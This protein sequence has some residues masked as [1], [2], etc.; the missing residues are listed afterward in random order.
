[1]QDA[2]QRVNEI[3]RGWVNY[4]RVGNASRA[5]AKV[6]YDVELKVRRFAM[7]QR[8]RSGFGWKR[9]SH[10]RRDRPSA[11][12]RVWAAVHERRCRRRGW[13]SVGPGDRTRLRR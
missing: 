9:W 12:P 8:K 11:T 6:R 7:R 2:V 10:A 1:M 13:A 5:F 4:F 3:V